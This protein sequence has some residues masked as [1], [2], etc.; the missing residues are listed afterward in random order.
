MPGLAGIITFKPAEKA[1]REL[2]RMLEAMRH[3]P[4]YRSGTWTDD[5]SGVYVGWMERDDPGHATMPQQSEDG[6]R[7]LAFSGQEFPA[8]GAVQTLRDLGH[9]FGPERNAHLVHLA[10]EDVAFPYSL[11]GNFHGVLIDRV[12]H[13]ATLFNDR[14]S[15][16]RLYIHETEEA[17]YFAAEAKAILAV[18]PELR[19]LDD[20]GLAEYVSCGCVLQDRSLFKNIGILPRAAAWRFRHGR[21]ET[22]GTYFQDED[23]EAEALNPAQFYTELRS[24]FARNLSRYFDDSG[25]VG[26][27]L[28]GGLDTRMMLAWHKPAP[29]SVRC[30][31]FGGAYREC[32]DVRIA[33]R[34]AEAC[35]QSHEVIPVGSEFLGRFAHYAERTVYLTDGAT[36]VHQAPDLYVNEIAR[37]I[38]PIRLTGNYGDEV[39]R[40]GIVFR[41]SIPDG[42]LFQPEFL[43]QAARAGRTYAEEFRNGSMKDAASRQVSW[44]FCGLASLESSQVEM[45][46]PFLDNDLIRTLRR[47]PRSMTGFGD[48]RVRMIRDGDPRLSRIRTDQGYAGRGGPVATAIS[49][50]WNRASMRA[51]YAFENGDPR[52]V[53]ALDRAL[54]GRTLEKM[55]VGTHKFTHFGLWYRESLANY[56]RE[57]LLDS[58]TLSRP[59]LNRRAVET[60]VGEHL[61]GAA[62]HTPAI[63]KLITLEYIHRLFV[64]A[65]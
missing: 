55:F 12:Q 6:R 46:S 65:S 56:V 30:Y 13:S 51:E 5:S 45:R 42:E 61:S 36:G 2:A 54:L 9:R 33:R 27:S 28:T 18:K 57:M 40:R 24:V 38:A 62:N 25:R 32:R 7:V 31:T 14:H 17:F 64:D 3:E 22:R 15:S 4:F 21:R 19:A 23:W 53:P 34:V 60:L 41:P 11:N 20:R 29:Q 50:F 26:L 49:R 44:F 8:P 35:G 52:W 58:R 10:E 47:A 16:R 59:Y 43:A 48:V 39:I 1:R 37:T 63:H